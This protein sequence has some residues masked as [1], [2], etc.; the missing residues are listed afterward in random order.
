MTE[1]SPPSD[2]LP[3]C[4]APAWLMNEGWHV[5]ISLPCHFS[6]WKGSQI[7]DFQISCFSDSDSEIQCNPLAFWEARA[8]ERI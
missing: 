1:L 4:P 2:Q 6:K 7:L 8:G 3:A 5:V